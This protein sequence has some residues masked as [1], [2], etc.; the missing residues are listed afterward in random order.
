M[1]PIVCGPR[2]PRGWFLDSRWLNCVNVCVWVETR[3]I[4][5]GPQSFCQMAEADRLA[6]GERKKGR[7]LGLGAGAVYA[8][9][10]TR[11][12]QVHGLILFPP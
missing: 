10:Y 8:R 11:H 5:L 2:E 6:F 12:F 7:G 1:A 3:L 9:S 4:L